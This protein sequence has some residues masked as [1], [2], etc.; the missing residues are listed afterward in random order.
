MDGP[1]PQPALK[2]ALLP[3]VLRKKKIIQPKGRRSRGRR[4][5]P[6]IHNIVNIHGLYYMCFSLVFACLSVR[7]SVWGM[8]LRS[9]A[10]RLT[11]TYTSLP[12]PGNR[13][14]NRYGPQSWLEPAG[15]AWA[16]ASTLAP[17][18]RART[19]MRACV[20]T[21][22]ICVKVCTRGRVTSQRQ[23]GGAA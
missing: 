19:H 21:W 18:V 1:S 2:E 22:G 14:W 4:I 5:V 10:Q 15:R 8:D 11:L 13:T 7:L 23:A 9:L 17:K 3:G 20:C 16:S 12:H 6:F